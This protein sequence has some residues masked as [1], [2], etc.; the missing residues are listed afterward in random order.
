[1]GE[2]SVKKVAALVVSIIGLELV[3][4]IYR[5]F[6]ER[7]W[8]IATDLPLHMCGFSVFATLGFVTKNQTV[9]YHISGVWWALQAILTPDPSSM[10]IISTYFH[11]WFLMD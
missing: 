1:M 6:D 9:F 7:G 5:V 8:F 10:L 4:D 3:D 2:D 11:L